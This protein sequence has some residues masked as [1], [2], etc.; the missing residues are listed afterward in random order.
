MQ[1]A[2]LC[3]LPAVLWGP[4]S[5]KAEVVCSRKQWPDDEN[6]IAAL[7]CMIYNQHLLWFAW[8]YTTTY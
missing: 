2:Y 4:G 1:G 5:L 3:Y 7:D 8:V 6:N